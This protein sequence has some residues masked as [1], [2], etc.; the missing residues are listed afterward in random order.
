MAGRTMTLGSWKR[1]LGEAVALHQ[2]PELL[3]ISPA[4]V[5]K[6]V[7]RKSLPV[8]SFRLPDGP[9]IRMVRRSDLDLVK[10]SLTPPKLDD[11]I[12]AMQIVVGQDKTAGTRP[13]NV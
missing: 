8:Y 11:L 13:T 3:G 7:K 2:T 5:G 9:V 6:L 10:K 12:A 4:H 1:W